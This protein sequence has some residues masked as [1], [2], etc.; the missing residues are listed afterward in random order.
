MSADQHG[1]GGSR[2]STVEDDRRVYLGCSFPAAQ[3]AVDQLLDMEIEN[4]RSEWRWLRLSNGDLMLGFFP[5]ADGEDGYF[6]TELVR[7][8]DWADAGRNDQIS[9]YFEEIQNVI[10]PR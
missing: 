2:M 1:C 9:E 10:L 4:G 5:Q 6:A 7:E 3:I 8:Q